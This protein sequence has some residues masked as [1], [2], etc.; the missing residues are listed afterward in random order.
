MRLPV[1]VL[2][3][4]A[5]GFFSSGSQAACTDNISDATVVASSLQ[6][7]ANHVSFEGVCE[8]DDEELIVTNDVSQ[9]NACVLMSTAGAVD[10]LVSLDGTTFSTDP[11]SLEDRGAAD[12][13][14]VL[15][16]TAG[17]LYAFGM[18][19]VRRIKVV[20]NGATGAEATLNCG[21]F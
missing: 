10:V 7:L 3:L 21:N 20:Q 1:I 6:V 8:N 17:R 11:I 15:V 16:T 13:T 14:P 4:L 2:I 18:I 5:A 12:L 9:F 19:G